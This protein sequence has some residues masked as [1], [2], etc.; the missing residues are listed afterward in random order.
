M[1]VTVQQSRV[2]SR[3]RLTSDKYHLF[4]W[5][6]L[7][8]HCI[9]T[10]SEILGLPVNRSKRGPFLRPIHKALSVVEISLKCFYYGLANQCVNYAVDKGKT[11][12]NKT[13]KFV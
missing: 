5:L 3:D 8:D 7:C 2:I 13:Q 6:I 4:R 10:E 12:Q 11:K 1:E 9:K